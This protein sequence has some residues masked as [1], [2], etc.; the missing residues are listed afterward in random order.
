[1]I[2]HRSTRHLGVGALLVGIVL[3]AI[4]SYYVLRNTFGFDLAELD[5]EAIWPIL[6]VALGLGILERTWS[7]RNE[8]PRT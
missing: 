2:T 7:G 6:V 5:G 1:M 3:I 8:G 4:G